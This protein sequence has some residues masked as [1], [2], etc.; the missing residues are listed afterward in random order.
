MPPR[1]ELDK[2][3]PGRVIA[4]LAEL[5]PGS[6]ERGPEPVG[7]RPPIPPTAAGSADAARRRPAPPPSHVAPSPRPILTPADA[8]RNPIVTPIAPTPRPV[9]T[10]IR[11]TGP[12]GQRRNNDD[13]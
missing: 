6:T 3:G 2:A 9:A 4:A 10:A 13:I 7:A 8:W 12:K 1:R 11:T 5:L